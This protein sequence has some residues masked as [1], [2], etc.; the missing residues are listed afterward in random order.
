MYLKRRDFLRVVATAGGALC[1]GVLMPRRGA[2]VVPAAEITA[3]VVVRS[4][5]AVVVRIARSEMGQGSQ[6]GLAILVAEE[7]DCD[8]NRVSTEFVSVAEHLRRGR[9]WGSMLTGGSLAIR[10]SQLYLRTAGAAARQM[11][12]TAAANRWS[13]PT[14]ECSVSHGVITHRPTGR[15]FGFGQVATEAAMLPVPTNVRLKDP[16]EWKLIGQPLQ[17]LDLRDKVLGRPVFAVDVQLPGMLHASIAQSPV[18]GGTLASIQNR[19]AI[20]KRRGVVRI[21]ELADAVAVVADNWWRADQALR[22]LQ[23]RWNEGADAKASSERVMADLRSGLDADKPP[24]VTRWGDAG[25]ILAQGTA[26]EAVYETPYLAHAT[27]EPQ[28]CT[29][30]RRGDR[31]EVW[32]AT[33]NGEAT[34]EAVATAAQVPLQN[35]EVH[36]MQLGGGFGRRGAVPMQDAPRLAAQIAS[37]LPGR[38]IKLMWSRREDMQHDFYRPPSVVRQRAALDS[39]GKWLAWSVRVAAPSIEAF[40]DPKRDHKGLDDDACSC[41]SDSPYV[42][43][44]RL[45]DYAMRGTPVPI[46][47]WRAVYHS[48]NPFMRECFVDEVAAASGQDPYQFRRERLTWHAWHGSGLLNGAKVVRRAWLAREQLQRNLAVLDAAA[49]VA[50]WEQPAPRGRHRGIAL[51]DGYG[52]YTAAVIELSLDDGGVVQLHR[53]VVAIDPGYVVNPDSARA[54]IEGAVVFGL[55]AAMYGENTLKDGRIVE[56]NFHDYEM[57]TL[58]QCPPIESVLVP[59]GGFWGGMGEPPLMPVAPALVNALAT[60]TGKRFRSLPLMKHGFTLGA[61]R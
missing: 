48:Q 21:V 6:T 10:G 28:T 24:V 41:F 4:D 47:Y 54:Q 15:Q 43:P 44:H 49:R 51:A 37:H 3:W 50:G 31:L 14:V 19:N 45:V 20:L 27:L 17:R 2:A 42:V 35:V 46:G 58:A 40:F 13:V 32:A 38:P 18:F 22:A 12:T 23:I 53:V 29:A 39:R 7:L 59:S 1:L 11:L 30:V 25:R 9:V 8:W 56:S 36:R 34:A 61:A 60:A 33:Q 5:G 55:T 26:V 52:S 57:M 16:R